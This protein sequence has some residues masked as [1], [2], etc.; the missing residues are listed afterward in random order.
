MKKASVKESTIPTTTGGDISEFFRD[1]HADQLEKQGTH[2]GQGTKAITVRI[3]A[4]EAALMEALASDLGV[5][6]NHVMAQVLNE[7]CWS[8]L[9]GAASVMTDSKGYHRRITEK[10][11]ALLASEESK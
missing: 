9:E 10:A 6:R 5:S 7:G 1:L 3:G 8:A 11:N 4:F 2:Q